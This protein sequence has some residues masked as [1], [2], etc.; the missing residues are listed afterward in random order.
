MTSWHSLRRISTGCVSMLAV[1]G[2][3]LGLPAPATPAPA[4]ATATPS[5][6][7]LSDLI[8]ASLKEPSQSANKPSTLD[9]DVSPAP[10]VVPDGAG[11]SRDTVGF[12][13]PQTSFIPAFGYS[14]AHPDVA[15]P[16]AND[17][18]CKPGA[19]QRPV[20]LVHGTFENAYD[21]FAMISPELKKAGY[22]TFT[23]N[24]GV[25]NIQNGGGGAR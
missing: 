20:V 15:P 22:C 25:L 9:P 10:L 3:G 18:G 23:F 14:I 17:F 13:P 8:A 7:Q 24:Y 6:K 21:N 12:G 16:G 2:L 4:P 5:L 11:T 19:G 1:A